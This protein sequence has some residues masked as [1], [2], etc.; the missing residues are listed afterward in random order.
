M[1]MLTTEIYSG[2]H[3]SV[4]WVEGPHGG[5]C[6]TRKRSRGGVMIRDEAHEWRDA[7]ATALDD[8]ERAALCRGALAP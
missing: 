3:Y 5:L 8:A 6:V 2:P 7:F 1:K 4:C